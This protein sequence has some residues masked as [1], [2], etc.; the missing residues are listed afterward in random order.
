VSVTRPK[1]GGGIRQAESDGQPPAEPAIRIRKERGE[2][3]T[4]SR[5]EV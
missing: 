1:I 2:G 4:V 5:F 3:R